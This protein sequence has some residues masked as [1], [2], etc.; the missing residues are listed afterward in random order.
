MPLMRRCFLLIAFLLLTGPVFAEGY[1]T[2]GDR[3]RP[4]VADDKIEVTAIFSYTCPHCYRLEPQ[5]EAWAQTLP[6]DVELVRLPAS[7][8]QQW[9]HRSRAYYIMEALGIFEEAHMPFFH[10]IHRDGQNMGSVDALSEFFADYGVSA[11]EVEDT[12][13]SFGVDRRVQRDTA[14]LRNFGVASVPTLIVDGQYQ[15][16]GRSAGSLSN[17]IRVADQLIQEVRSNR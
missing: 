17:M 16:D 10:A 12:Y 5:L 8:N 6:E 7:F 11:Q 4:Q 2:L 9:E 1:T 14:R 15:V 3:V 13:S